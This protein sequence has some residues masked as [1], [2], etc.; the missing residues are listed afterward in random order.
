VRR[1]LTTSAVI[2]VA[3]LGYNTLKEGSS[4]ETRSR[5][6]KEHE[7]VQSGSS[8]PQVTRTTGPVSSQISAAIRGEE[9]GARRVRSGQDREIDEL[10]IDDQ[11]F[12]HPEPEHEEQRSSELTFEE[13]QREE[14]RIRQVWYDGLE[15]RFG[16]QAVDSSWSRETQGLLKDS[17]AAVAP[18]HVS[19]ASVDCRMN[20]CKTSLLHK[21]TELPRDFVQGFATRMQ[22]GVEHHFRYQPGET[23]IYSIEQRR[24]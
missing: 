1:L 6:A 21:S 16:A 19:V 12:D 11:D 3:A 8:S 4:T 7:L 2:L 14:S 17:L 10:G 20:M 13:S 24:N 9:A 18:E 23:L 15:R 22:P 5:V